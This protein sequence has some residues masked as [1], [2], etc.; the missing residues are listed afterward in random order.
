MDPTTLSTC[1]PFPPDN[2]LRV[3]Q[4]VNIYLTKIIL[5]DESHFAG[6][7]C[8]PKDACSFQLNALPLDYVS[9]PKRQLAKF[10][11]PRYR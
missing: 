11:A 5:P 9:G 8:M 1:S 2:L 3:V 7:Y 10:F 6:I 4:Q